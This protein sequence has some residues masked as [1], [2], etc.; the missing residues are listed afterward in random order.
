MATEVMNFDTSLRRITPD[1]EE[2]RR[3]TSSVV[4]SVGSET[5]ARMDSNAIER[6]KRY[7]RVV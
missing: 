1:S 6:K 4:R 3:E 5:A 2:D 7:E